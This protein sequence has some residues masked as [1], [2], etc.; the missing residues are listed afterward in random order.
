[1]VSD[2]IETSYIP[3]ATAFSEL[4]AG[5]HAVLHEMVAWKRRIRQDWDK[6]VVRA[7]EVRGETEAIKGKEVEVVVTVDTAG[8][9]PQELNVELIHGPI[10]LWENF[11]VRHI[12]PLTADEASPETNGDWLFSGLIPLS[13]TGRYGYVV[14]VTPQH[15]NLSF[16]QRVDLVHRG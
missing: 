7:V 16:S 5:N 12:T 11:K 6:V 8:H 1:M 9:D 15:P 3:A 14:R 13:H 2:Y 10:D 4:R